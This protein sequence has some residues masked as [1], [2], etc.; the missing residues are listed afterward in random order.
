MLRVNDVSGWGQRWDFP[1][2]LFLFANGE[3]LAAIVCVA[4]LN[5][6][7]GDQIKIEHEQYVEYEQRPFRLV[8]AYIRKQLGI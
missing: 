2:F 4:L 5:R 8:T 3:S 7:N 1:D 6:M